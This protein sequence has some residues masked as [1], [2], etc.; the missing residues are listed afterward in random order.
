MPDVTLTIPDT[1]VPALKQWIDRVEPALPEDP[2]RSDAEYLAI[3][4]QQVRFMVQKAVKDT[5]WRSTQS[6]LYNNIPDM[7]IT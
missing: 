6:D 1:A 3:F 5:E 4:K 2:P 7:E